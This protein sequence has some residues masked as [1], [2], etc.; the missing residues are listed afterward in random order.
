MAGPVSVGTAQRC[1]PRAVG[2]GGGNPDPGS[3]APRNPLP[4]P[5]V[6]QVKTRSTRRQ[7]IKT[8]AS[9]API[10]ALR[11]RGVSWRCGACE[12]AGRVA[13]VPWPQQLQGHGP[14]PSGPGPRTEE[15][16]AR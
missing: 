13:S 10:S 5:V 9:T 8:S 11:L 4:S 15:H 16:G 6:R 3:L 7:P 12:G 2:G 1:C 14:D